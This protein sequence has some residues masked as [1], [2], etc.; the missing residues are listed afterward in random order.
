MNP[1][2]VILSLTVAAFSAFMVV[3]F[4]VSICVKLEDRQRARAS[5]QSAKRAGAGYAARPRSKAAVR[6]VTW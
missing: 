6:D 5:V 2:P 1:D 3:L 4:S